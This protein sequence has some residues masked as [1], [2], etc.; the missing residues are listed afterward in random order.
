MELF[1]LGEMIHIEHAFKS[2]NTHI[3]PLTHSVILDVNSVMSFVLSH[4]EQSLFISEPN[5]VYSSKM[6]I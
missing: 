3:A 4:S 2:I 5:K 1:A 6:M